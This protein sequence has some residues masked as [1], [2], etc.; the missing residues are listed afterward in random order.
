MTLADQLDQL[1]FE[2]F[3]AAAHRRGLELVVSKEHAGAIILE[4][5]ADAFLVH[6]SAFTTRR[7]DN[8]SAF[9]RF[10]AMVLLY[11]T[12][13][14]THQQ[15]GQLM[16]REYSAV[17]FGVRRGHQLLDERL[18]FSARL[19]TACIRVANRIPALLSPLSDFASSRGLP[20]LTDEHSS[21]LHG[22][23]D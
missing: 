8:R 2:E 7:R 17:V 9:P 15:V 19:H 6:R 3:Q 13:R 23:A 21:P 10:A 1:P 20:P 16:G 22:G 5:I 11:A 14:F 4:E 12:G 18:E